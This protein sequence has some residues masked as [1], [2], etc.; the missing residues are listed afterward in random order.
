MP[1]AQAANFPTTQ[2]VMNV[3]YSRF[4]TVEASMPSAT[5]TAGRGQIGFGYT[6]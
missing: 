1:T 3:T 4:K 5:A 2:V 6:W